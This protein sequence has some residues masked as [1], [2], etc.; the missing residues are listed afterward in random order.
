MNVTL[1]YCRSHNKGLPLQGKSVG[2]ASVVYPKM[3]INIDI[4]ALKNMMNT[5]MNEMQIYMELYI[6]GSRQYSYT[7]SNA[8]EGFILRVFSCKTGKSISSSD[9]RLPRSLARQNKV[10]GDN[11]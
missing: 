6:L 8:K 1:E 5:K 2:A 7:I 11:P 9:W 10:F 3:G 4:Y